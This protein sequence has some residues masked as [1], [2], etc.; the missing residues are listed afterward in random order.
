MKI[1]VQDFNFSFLQ[2]W[3]AIR[4]IVDTGLHYTGMKRDEAIK[5]FADKAWDDSDFTRKEV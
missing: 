2:I 1:G 3:R 4:M 5:L